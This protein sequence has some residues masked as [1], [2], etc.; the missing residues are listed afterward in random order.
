MISA[1]RYIMLVFRVLCNDRSDVVIAAILYF[2]LDRYRYRIGTPSKLIIV[3]M[4][5][6]E[7]PYR[8]NF[9]FINVDECSAHA[10]WVIVYRFL[11]SC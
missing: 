10:C 4:I 8:H 6:E 11:N 3:V 5:L 9:I 2:F 7:V 1:G